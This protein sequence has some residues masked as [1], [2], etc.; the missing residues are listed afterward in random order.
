[1]V[2]QWTENPC[3][4][5]SN[6]SITTPQE[7]TPKSVCFPFSPPPKVLSALSIR[8]TTRFISRV[9]TEFFLNT[10]FRG[11]IEP[12]IRCFVAVSL[13]K[14]RSETNINKT[15]TQQEILEMRKLA[16]Y[17]FR[18]AVRIYP[19]YFNVYI[20]MARVALMTG[21]YQ[22]GLD[23]VE[24]AIELDPENQYSYYFSLSLLEKTGDYEKYLKHAQILFDL[25]ENQESYGGLSRGYFLL[26]EY[27]KSKDVLLDGLSKYPDNEGLK[28]NLKFVEETMKN[29]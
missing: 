18:E 5:G 10:I 3:V 29:L 20:D 6:P 15:I 16:V 23:A 12:I 17:H 19:D 25:A 4:L 24:K 28:Y 27:Q 11:K 1:L 8:E 22:V 9:R 13:C 26:K 14:Y 7:S 21:E 2:E